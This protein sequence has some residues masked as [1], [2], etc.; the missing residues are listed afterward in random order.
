MAEKE[1]EPQSTG[2][3]L[4]Q[5]EGSLKQTLE[6]SEAEEKQRKDVPLPE[7]LVDAFVNFRQE[8]K[9]T[10]RGFLKRMR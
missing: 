5:E 1:A 2:T 4:P 7:Y 9:V 10:V 6:G 3:T 8:T